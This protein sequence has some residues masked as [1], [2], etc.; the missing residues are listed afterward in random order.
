MMARV[1][2]ALGCC[3]AL[4]CVAAGPGPG[5][6]DSPAARAAVAEPPFEVVGVVP[7]TDGPGR[8]DL[9][10]RKTM[11]TAGWDLAVESVDPAPAPDGTDRLRVDLVEVPPAGMVAQVLT[12]QEVRVALGPLAPGRHVVEVRTHVRGEGPPRFVQA[13]VVVAAR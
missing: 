10:L 13:V 9:V 6:A 2:T 8:F 3:A 11:R 5:P 4:A 12:P 7:A 1:T